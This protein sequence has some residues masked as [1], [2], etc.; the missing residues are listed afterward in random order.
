M[1]S[2]NFSKKI[3]SFGLLAVMAACAPSVQNGIGNTE[4]S[5]IDGHVITLGN[6]KNNLP[7][8]SVVRLRRPQDAEAAG[9]TGVLI[10]KQFVLTAAHCVNTVG[11]GTVQAEFE[12]TPEREKSIPVKFIDIYD[13]YNSETNRGDLALLTLERK[14]PRG[15]AVAPLYE[16]TFWESLTG[17][18]D[19][20]VEYFGYGCGARPYDYNNEDC[21]AGLLRKGSTKQ[22][23][24]FG[25]F[26][27]WRSG[28]GTVC[29][30]DS[31][32]P[33]FIYRGRNFYVVGIASYV[34]TSL[35]TVEE[36]ELQ[37]DYRGDKWSFYTDHPELSICQG[38]AAYTEIRRYKNWILD[39]QK[40]RRS[41][42]K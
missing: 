28:Q 27:R 24:F 30:G 2:N 29:S 15:Y 8:V 40:F 17:T 13:G 33:A 7:S 21:D 19:T 42:I 36:Q 9:C 22:A 18:D 39:R 10:G 26:V 1:A 35:S 16:Q 3:L 38:N 12:F 11:G 23:V 20:Y 34:T 31:G 32:G 37:Y 5:V 4:Q 14:F 25:D 41:A 6:R